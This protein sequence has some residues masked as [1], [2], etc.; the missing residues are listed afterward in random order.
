LTRI[1]RIVTVIARSPAPVLFLDSCVLLDVVRAPLRDK[2]GEVRVAG[3]LLTAVR[4]SPKAAH[5]LIAS[6]T[7]TEWNDHVGEAE[8]DCA[9]AVRAYNAV[10]S[11]CGHLGH[12]G[13]A[14]LPSLGA[15]LPGQLRQLSA[16]LLGA[17]GLIDHNAAALGRAADRII[18]ATPPAK[19]GGKGAKDSIILEHVVETTASLRQAGFTA[20][21]VFVSSNT[22]D[23][24]ASAGTTLSPA[25]APVF[26]PVQLQYAASL[27][28]AEAI[29]LAAG[30]V[31]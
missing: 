11:V 10:A 18:A 7:P 2:P 6:P 9:T 24:A 15:S 4:K 31:P 28:H 25:L 12:G 30:W 20:A 13:V 17:A 23:F 5:L 26:H 21:C 8:V 29:L 19:P 22:K 16:D 1:G 27:E 3:R 14:F